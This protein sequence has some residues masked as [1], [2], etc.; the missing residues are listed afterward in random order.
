MNTRFI[1]A[2]ATAACLL[3][4]SQAAADGN[5][6]AVCARDRSAQ[7]IG[8]P[9]TERIFGWIEQLTAA[10]PRRTGTPANA[11]AAAFM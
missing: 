7:A 1:P 11:R 8:M 9:S 2:M 10:G 3:L 5:E 4:S 6:D